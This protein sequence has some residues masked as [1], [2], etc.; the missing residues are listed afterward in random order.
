M[1]EPEA[2]SSEEPTL[3]ALEQA[4]TAF[5]LGPCASSCADVSKS[6]GGVRV[7][8]DVNFACVPAKWSDLLGDNGA[9]KSTLIKIMTGVHPPDTGEMFF[10]G[11]E[12]RRADRSGCART[13]HRDGFP[14]ARAGRAAA[15]VAQHLHGPPD[16]ESPG[17]SERGRDAQG[18]RRA[19]GRVDGFH[20]RGSDAGHPRHRPVRRRAPGPRDRARAPF[21]GRRDHPRRADDGPVAQGDRQAAPLR[22]RHQEGQQVGHLHRPQH[23]PRLLGRG[24]HRPTRSRSRRRRFPNVALFARGADRDHARACRKWPLHRS[25]ANAGRTTASSTPERSNN[26]HCRRGDG[27]AASNA[28]D[29]VLGHLGVPDRNHRRLRTAVAH[30]SSCLR[31]THSCSR[32][33]LPLVRA[34]DALLR[35]R[36][37]DR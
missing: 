37:D 30:C 22:V 20:V 19:D 27:L 9:G 26:E 31:R 18:H 15:L 12:G 17:L 25:R 24:S 16:R 14:G 36:R 8:R 1:L 5:P 33:D 2:A 4:S 10:D 23:L 7:L 13:G 35:D 11:Q 29:P 3:A 21:R 6:F 32:P 28:P 34:D